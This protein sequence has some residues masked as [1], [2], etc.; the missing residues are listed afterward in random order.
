MCVFCWLFAD[1]WLWYI[2][3]LFVVK[4]LT[5]VVCCA[6]GAVGLLP[7]RIRCLSFAVCCLLVFVVGSGFLLAV[8]CCPPL[9]VN[10]VLTIYC[11]LLFAVRC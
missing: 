4:C 1:R 5:C 7:F 6:V 10:C 3:L 11:C 9:S 8:D 2:V